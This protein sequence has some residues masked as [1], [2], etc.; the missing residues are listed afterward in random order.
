LNIFQYIEMFY[1]PKRR[2]T[3]NGRVSPAEYENRYFRTLESV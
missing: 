2:H 1:N 3:A